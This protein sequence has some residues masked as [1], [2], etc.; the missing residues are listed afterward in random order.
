MLRLEGVKGN[1]NQAGWRNEK[2]ETYLQAQS[3]VIGF[4]QSFT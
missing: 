1:G 4:Q 2:G 3:V